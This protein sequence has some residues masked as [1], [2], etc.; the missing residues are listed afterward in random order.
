MFIS[1]ILSFEVKPSMQ[2]KKIT[3]FISGCAGSLL[4]YEFFSSWGKRGLLSSC[5]VGA[6]HC[7]GF[8]V[9]ERGRL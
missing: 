2:L 4:L 6:S 3:Y 7:G 1:E 8:F 9:A 5:G